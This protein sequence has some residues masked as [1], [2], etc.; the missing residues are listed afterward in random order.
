MFAVNFMVAKCLEKE[1]LSKQCRDFP[2]VNIDDNLMKH[3]IIN[4]NLDVWNK[5]CQ[6]ILDHGKHGT[7]WMAYKVDE[8]K[9]KL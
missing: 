7:A 1:M 8:K 3:F 4:E 9:Q 2:N 6:I 5:I